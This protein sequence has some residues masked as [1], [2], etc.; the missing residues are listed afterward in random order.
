M[1]A[2]F[3]LQHRQLNPILGVECNFVKH[4]WLTGRGASAINRRPRI[5]ACFTARQ[6]RPHQGNYARGVHL[7]EI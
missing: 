5:A 2:N 6:L 7:R 1:S 4:F 3:A